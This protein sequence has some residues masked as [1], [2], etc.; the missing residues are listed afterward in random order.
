MSK[1]TKQ[2][3]IFWQ[4]MIAYSHAEKL[5][6]L[7]IYR[8]RRKLLVHKCDEKKLTRKAKDIMVD[9]FETYA[10]N[11]D[12]QGSPNNVFAKYQRFL[13]VVNLHFDN[14]LDTGV[15]GDI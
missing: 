11:G 7:Q 6:R 3:Q 2:E 5:E 14:C 1:L 8:Q 13:N 9:F 10:L 15:G 12:L 4:S